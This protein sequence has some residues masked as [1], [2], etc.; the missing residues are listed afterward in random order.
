MN[1][2]AEPNVLQHMYLAVEVPDLGTD[3][4]SVGPSDQSC[5]EGEASGTQ[6]CWPTHNRHPGL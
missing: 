2:K 3:G 4:V 5:G 6:M 1:K